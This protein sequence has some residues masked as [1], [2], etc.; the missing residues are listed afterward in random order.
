M[1]GHCYIIIIKSQNFWAHVMSIGSTVLETFF[2]GILLCRPVTTMILKA[3]KTSVPE[4]KT[5]KSAWT[6]CQS[7]RGQTQS[8]SRSAAEV[9]Y[10]C[11]Q[12]Q[13]ISSPWFPQQKANGIFLLRSQKD[14]KFELELFV[15]AQV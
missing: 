5:R 4:N 9:M 8:E 3:L 13:E 6:V 10:F 1:M 2:V 15:K 12:I 14:R 11:G 7:I